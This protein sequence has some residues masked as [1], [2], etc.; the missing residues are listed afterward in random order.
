LIAIEVRGKKQKVRFSPR[1]S[2]ADKK[3]QTSHA[4]FSKAAIEVLEYTHTERWRQ[5][6][7]VQQ[8]A[9]L[10]TSARSVKGFDSVK[11]TFLPR[12]SLPTKLYIM[13]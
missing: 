13:H 5:R 11:D 6:R 10:M 12:D 1:I 7:C 3:R 9:G 2:T 4:R 8:G